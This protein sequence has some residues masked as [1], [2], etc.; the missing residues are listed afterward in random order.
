MIAMTGST[1]A[2]RD[3]PATFDDQK[4]QVFAGKMLAALSNAALVLMASVGHRT[5]LLAQLASSPPTTS[6]DLAAK[7]GLAE[8]YVRE[9][10]AVMTTAGVVVYDPGYATYALPAEHA[11]FL[12]DGGPVNIAVNSQFLAVTAGVEDEIVAR[13]R[14]GKGMH[15]H[16]YGRFHEVM[17]E[18]SDQSIASKLLDHILPLV[19]GIRARL[20]KGIDVLDVGCG[21]GR[22]LLLLARQFPCSRF[23]GLDACAD[24]FASAGE[25]ARVDRLGN[26][27]FRACDISGL[28]TLGAYDLVLAFDA[29]H[30]QKNPQGMLRAIRRSLRRDGAFLMADIGGSSDLEKNIPHP[31]GPFIFMMSCMHCMPISLGQGGPGLGAMWGVELASEMLAAAGFSNVRMSRLAHDIV[32]AYFVARP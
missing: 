30:D 22:A 26:L 6:V 13:F 8:R 18:V 17:A 5:G 31:L 24:A 11:A 23:V 20:E 4:A 19:P 12:T 3:E 1:T 15:Y 29:V 32:N 7:A 9:W 25:A 14:D 21:G 27:T 16:H 10:L 28:E 2:R